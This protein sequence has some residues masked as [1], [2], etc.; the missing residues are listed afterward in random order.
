VLYYFQQN[1][2]MEPA[3]AF[4]VALMYLVL[5][6]T[7]AAFGWKL[8]T[9]INT[10]KTQAR[11]AAQLKLCF[12]LFFSFFFIFFLLGPIEETGTNCVFVYFCL[13]PSGSLLTRRFRSCAARC[14][15]LP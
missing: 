12:F 2:W 5:S 6:I 1:Q 8:M 4:F 15:W 13:I 10:T 9:L 7:L 11:I 3:L 14:G